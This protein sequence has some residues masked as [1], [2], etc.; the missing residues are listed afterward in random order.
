M[1]HAKVTG[2]KEVLKALKKL[3]EQA[4]RHAVRPA[5]RKA[6]TPI[7]KAAKKLIPKG[8]GLNPDGTARKHLKQT[9]TKTPVKLHKQS[10]TLYI[11]IGPEKDTGFHA[12]LVH[13]GTQAHDIVLKKPLNLGGT[14][15]PKGFVIHHP[16][17]KA[18]PYLANA[19]EAT[20][21]KVLGILQREIL[22][23]IEKQTAKLAGKI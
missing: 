22:A 9:V 12:H 4:R 13:D 3:P 14:I 11:V 7:V 20:R 10:G 1:I 15:L 18:N 6:S 21:S 8:K 17:A 5:I 2:L 19:V 16:G 23:G